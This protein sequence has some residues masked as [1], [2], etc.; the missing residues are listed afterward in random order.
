ML[1]LRAKAELVKKVIVP[2]GLEP[3]AGLVGLDPGAG[4]PGGVGPDAADVDAA[5]LGL[6]T[7]ADLLLLRPDLDQLLVLPHLGGPVSPVVAVVQAESEHPKAVLGPLGALQV[8]GVAVV[9]PD[10]LLQH[11]LGDPGRGT[12]AAVEYVLAHRRLK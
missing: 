9:A 6:G 2:L 7:G 4:E 11:L 12:V 1:T 10:V 5:N 3:E 8:V